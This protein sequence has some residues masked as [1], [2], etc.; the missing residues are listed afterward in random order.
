MAYSCGCLALFPVG[1]TRVKSPE[2]E[3]EEEEVCRS[4]LYRA[5]ELLRCFDVELQNR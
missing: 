4:S 2:E 5:V 3:E 1:M